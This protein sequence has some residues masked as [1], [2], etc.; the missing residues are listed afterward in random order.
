MYE[1]SYDP[2]QALVELR[3]GG[4]WTPDVAQAF[5]AELSAVISKARLS[6][7]FCVLSDAREFSVQSSDVVQ[8][9]SAM[10][11]NSLAERTAIVVTSALAR[12]QARRSM[13]NGRVRIFSDRRSRLT[14]ASVAS[15]ARS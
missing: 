3:L 13:E 11:E 7:P 5:T 15:V 1:I 2:E 9:F 14:F 12:S 10:A 8:R 6:G 4:F